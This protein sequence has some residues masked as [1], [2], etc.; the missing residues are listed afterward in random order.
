MSMLE[1][2]MPEEIPKE[3]RLL[4]YVKSNFFVPSAV[5]LCF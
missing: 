2:R 3:G 1:L 4:G 5:N